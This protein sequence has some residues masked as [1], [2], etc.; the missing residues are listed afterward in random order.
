MLILYLEGKGGQME[1]ILIHDNLVR[2]FFLIL[3]VVVGF[4]GYKV[5]TIKKTADLQKELY[6]VRESELE[7]LREKNS[8][9][10]LENMSLENKNSVLTETVH[11]KLTEQKAIQ[12]AEQEERIPK[13]LPVDG[14]AGIEE[15]KDDEDHPL[16][17]FSLGAETGVICTGSGKV[18][19]VTEDPL[20]G[21]MIRVDHGDGYVSIYR[22]SGNPTIAE[23]DQI[24]RGIKL[25]VNSQGNTVLGYQLMLDG[26]YINPVEVME[27]SG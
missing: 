22:S 20:Y 18:E 26:E 15:K 6:Q 21:V 14:Q 13:G 24:S 19:A 17:E 11:Q 1:R 27:I 9:L 7:D 23:G 5:Y 8:A 10:T 4:A 25:F 2:I 12:T 16:V 3:L